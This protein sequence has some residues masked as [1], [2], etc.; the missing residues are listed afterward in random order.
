MRTMKYYWI[1]LI[2]ILFNGF[3]AKGQNKGIYVDTNGNT[4]IGGTTYPQTRL[5][6]SGQILS[7]G[8]GNPISKPVPIQGA[9]IDWNRENTG[10]TY[11][12][13]HRGLGAGGFK[14]YNADSQGNLG[15]QIF[16]ITGNGNV[17]IGSTNPG[18]KLTISPN[19]TMGFT[20]GNLPN[21][22]MSVGAYGANPSDGIGLFVHDTISKYEGWIGAIRSGNENCG[23]WG[24]KTMRF[25][26]PDASSNVINALNI[27]GGSGNVG[28]GSTTP[29][30]ILDVLGSGVSASNWVYFRGN[31]GTG[32]G[33]PSSS[34]ASGLMYGWN[35]SGGQG[36]SQILYATVAG[37]EPRLDFGRWNGNTKTIDMTL[38]GGNVGIGTISPQALLDIFGSTIPV[39]NNVFNVV[40]SGTSSGNYA[41]AISSFSN[42]GDGFAIMGSSN[43]IWTTLKTINSTSN[44]DWVTGI[45]AQVATSGDCGFGTNGT[46]SSNCGSSMFTS[47]KG[48]KGTTMLTSPLSTKVEIQFSGQGKLT[49]GKQEV[50]FDNNMSE[51]IAEQTYKVL[52]TPTEECN[53][54]IVVK[55]SDNGFTVTELGK[56]TS[57]ATFD[58][59]LIA[60]K[61]VS[62]LDQSAHPMLKTEPKIMESVQKIPSKK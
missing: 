39:N 7:T 15:N 53:G 55:K 43:S 46:I 48:S 23:A 56:G 28:I 34:A 44:S 13:N 51:L 54:L 41:T 22:V 17:G 12:I 52:L 1:F 20:A 45:F 26:V 32:S 29:L 49:G 30:G 21:P 61:A 25:Q 27:L 47:F 16:T 14:F 11:F 24:C 58:W 57:N 42:D 2:V 62:A 37:G 35:P 19:I 31:T 3:T 50:V 33:N 59:F 6:V 60:N 4:A 38:N 5:S 9:Y 36:E 18:Q 10:N 8:S 40:G